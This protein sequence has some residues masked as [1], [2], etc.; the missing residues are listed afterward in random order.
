MQSLIGIGNKVKTIASNMKQL[1]DLGLIGS[2]MASGMRP[3]YRITT[4]LTL[5]DGDVTEVLLANTI[6]DWVKI[7][8][9]GRAFPAARF[10]TEV[11]GKIAKDK[12]KEIKTFMDPIEENNVIGI[13]MDESPKNAY[14]YMIDVILTNVPYR[15]KDGTMKM[16]AEDF[17]LL[18]FPVQIS[19]GFIDIDGNFR[20]H[21]NEPPITTYGDVPPDFTGILGALTQETFTQGDFF[22]GTFVG[23]EYLFA[24]FAPQ[25]RFP[26]KSGE[27]V[28][29]TLARLLRW[30]ALL[31]SVYSTTPANVRSSKHATIAIPILRAM[32]VVEGTRILSIPNIAKNIVMVDMPRDSKL[33][34]SEI[35]KFPGG[36]TWWIDTGSFAEIIEHIENDTNTEIFFNEYGRLTVSGKPKVREIAERRYD[37]IR[38]HDAIIGHN[39]I[40]HQA[41]VDLSQIVNRVIIHK[42]FKGINAASPVMFVEHPNAANLLRDDEVTKYYGHNEQLNVEHKYHYAN[43]NI[44]IASNMAEQMIDHF[45]YY[46]MRGKCF[47]IG[48][49][50]IRVNDVLRVSDIRSFGIT[51]MN[52]PQTVANL[53]KEVQYTLDN[54]AK[55]PLQYDSLIEKSFR[56]ETGIDHF[57]IWKVV[58]YIGSDGFKTKVFYTKENNSYIPGSDLLAQ[59]L[60]RHKRGVDP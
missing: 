39:V 53:S 43:S 44:G 26:L 40:H 8:S 28:T 56:L 22:Q 11:L 59:H 58:H 38:V 24:R 23:F 19:T 5:S 36:K 31:S 18:G 34:R 29:H 25:E 9:L 12:I 51:G 33:H 15:D 1:D 6:P 50:K 13:L 47:M 20:K 55:T 46:G 60:R 7:K 37:R 54:V 2:S 48:N 3:V 14:R 17:M 52:D 49:P 42:I 41:T 4:S 27:P 45:R 10:G 16:L 35:S 57:H 30:L 32:G 21:P